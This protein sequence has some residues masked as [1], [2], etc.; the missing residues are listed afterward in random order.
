MLVY[1][2]VKTKQPK[3]LLLINYHFLPPIENIGHY[4]LLFQ[5]LVRALN[6]F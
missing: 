1:K 2:M 5:G 4:E 3:L 6:V